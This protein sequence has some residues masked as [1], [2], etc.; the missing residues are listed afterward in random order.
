MIL[1]IINKSPHSHNC[2]TQ[3]LQYCRDNCSIIFIENG[4][5][6]VSAISSSQLHDIKR[7]GITLY[8]LKA[9]VLAR[10]LKDKMPEAFS[11]VDDNGFVDLT[12]SHHSSQ[13]WF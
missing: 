13:S 2:L 5:H 12:I 3:C 10:G 6:A 7:R 9:D 1:H 4:V 8:L 11:L